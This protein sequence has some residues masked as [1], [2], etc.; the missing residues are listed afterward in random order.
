VPWLVAHARRTLGVIRQNIAFSLGMKGLFVALTF[1][2]F[3]TLWG[4][5][6]ADLGTSLLVVANALR[7]LRPSSPPAS[8]ETA[9]AQGVPAAAE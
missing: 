5:I 6:A 1:A 9:A 8:D 4:A 7:L 2:G 3:A